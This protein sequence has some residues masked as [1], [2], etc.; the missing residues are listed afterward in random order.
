[1]YLVDTNVWLELLLEQERTS[2]VRRFLGSVDADQLSLTEFALGLITT[3]LRKQDVFE[4]FISD[5]L[6]NSAVRRRWARRTST[7]C[8]KLQP[9][10]G[11]G[12]CGAARFVDREAGNGYRKVG[13]GLRSQGRKHNQGCDQG[14]RWWRGRT[15]GAGAGWPLDLWLSNQHFT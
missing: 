14:P 13:A 4:A 1:M 8:L 7:S 6:E 10:G 9:A 12:L 5:I 15:A 3:R 11:A 2:E